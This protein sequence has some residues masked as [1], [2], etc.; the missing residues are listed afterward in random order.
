MNI[1]EFMAEF[2]YIDL[3]TDEA[4]EKL[5][6]LNRKIVM[7]S[8]RL[9]LRYER[10]MC[11]LDASREMGI[12]GFTGIFKNPDSVFTGMASL[13]IRKARYNKKEENFAYLWDLRIL[14]TIHPQTKN[15][16]FK[17]YNCLLEKSSIVDEFNRPVRFLTVV[18]SHNKRAIKFLKTKLPG[19][20]YIELQRINTNLVFAPKINLFSKNY[21]ISF[22]A[23]NLSIEAFINSSL[24]NN[25][26]Y[27]EHLKDSRKFIIVK[28]KNGKIQGLCSAIV[29]NKRSL[30]V[31]KVDSFIQIAIKL[32]KPFGVKEIKNQSSLKQLYFDDLFI[33]EKLSLKEKQKILDLLIDFAF[34]NLR[35]SIDFHAVAYISYPGNTEE[36]KS[37]SIFQFSTNAILFEV[38]KKCNKKQVDSSFFYKL[39]TSQL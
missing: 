25:T 1:S 17:F 16:W 24:K 32:M 8:G 5:H 31:E 36:V 9:Q 30:F 28:D 29:M 39:Q 11:F 23:K 37:E 12:D 3:A 2:K 19:L 26:Y 38:R 35:K 33:C 4:N 18:L 27:E 34:K 22:E 21:D 13:A 14:N 6:A 7:N 15:E 20:D 10:S